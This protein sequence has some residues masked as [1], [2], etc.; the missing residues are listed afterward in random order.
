MISFTVKGNPQAL[1]RHRT[2]RR[3]S[4]LIQVD[5]SKGDKADFIAAVQNHIPDQPIQGPV[6][7]AC[8]FYFQRPKAHYGTGKNAAVLKSSSPRIHF[9]RPDLD[10]LLKLVKDALTSGGFWLDD[11]QVAHING[12][13]YYSRRPRTEVFI[14]RILEI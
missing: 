2:F 11:S 8:K 1:K 7:L 5:P 4:N 9:K 13:K 12:N 14:N 6:F 10:N 3:G